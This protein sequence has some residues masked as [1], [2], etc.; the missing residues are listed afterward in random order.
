LILDFEPVTVNVR[1]GEEG[2]KIVDV[3]S[4]VRGSP[5]SSHVVSGIS[6]HLSR[7]VVDL[8]GY[9]REGKS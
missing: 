9:N 6:T 1:D 2:T 8:F 3:I 7:D 5:N 4:H